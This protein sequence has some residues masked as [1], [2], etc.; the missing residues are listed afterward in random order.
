MALT[1]NDGHPRFELDG[2]RLTL[3]YCRSALLV[4]ALCATGRVYGADGASVSP[5]A[6][7]AKMEYCE[8]C[9]GVSA[10]GFNKDFTRFRDWRDKQSITSKTS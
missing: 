4:I 7:R 9:H 3:G 6:V 5:Q 2:R 10:Q 1:R 8:V